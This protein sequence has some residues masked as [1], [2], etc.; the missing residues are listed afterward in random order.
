MRV[1]APGV[2]AYANRRVVL[3]IRPEDLPMAAVDGSGDSGTARRRSKATSNSSRRSG[4]TLLIHFSIDA[5]RVEVEGAMEDDDD[6]DAGHACRPPRASL[7][8]NRGR[9]CANGDRVRLAV[10]PIRLHF[11]D[12]ET[13]DAVVD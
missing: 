13:G 1:T 2:R 4:R 12:P 8:S 3:G 9:R 6:L 5:R 10:N 11:F 7:G